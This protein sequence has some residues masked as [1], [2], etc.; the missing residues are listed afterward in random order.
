VLLFSNCY[1]SQRLLDQV[2]FHILIP[3]LSLSQLP[4][5]PC[6]PPPHPTP[7]HACF[8]TYTNAAQ[9]YFSHVLTS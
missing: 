7:L 5:S 3:I 4:A 6:Y 8:L 9:G 1:I 2:S